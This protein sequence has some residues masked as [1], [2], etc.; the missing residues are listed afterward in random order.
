MLLSGTEPRH[1]PWRPPGESY[2]GIPGLAFAIGCPIVFAGIEQMA[3]SRVQSAIIDLVRSRWDSQRRLYGLSDLG[4]QLRRLFPRDE[5]QR[6]FLG[7]KLKKYI[8]YNLRHELRIVRHPRD[9]LVWGVVPIGITDTEDELFAQ[10]PTDFAPRASGKDTAQGGETGERLPYFRYEHELWKAF[11]TA[12]VGDRY[13]E[14]GEQIIVT[15]VPKGESGPE[16][17]LKLEAA[18]FSDAREGYAAVARKIEAWAERNKTNISRFKQ[19]GR[20]K[21][22]LLELMIEALSDEDLRQLQLP[23]NVIKILSLKRI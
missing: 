1:G 12:V 11:S 14:L 22:S 20:F 3:G 4:L 6:E 17:S 2:R 5:L 8:E 13:V 7:G 23:M 16:R 18:D 19:S 10:E 9:S 15:D 21:K